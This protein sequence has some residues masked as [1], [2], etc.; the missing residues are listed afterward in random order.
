MRNLWVDIEA[1][2]NQTAELNRESV[3]TISQLDQLKKFTRVVSDTGDFS[4]LKQYAPEDA[5]T[6]PTLIL[7]AAQMPEY[8]YILEKATVEGKKT[9][10][11]GKALTEE[12]FNRLLVGFGVEILKIV[13]NR[14]S[15][16]TAAE[17]SFDVP[18]ILGEAR[19]FIELYAKNG[20]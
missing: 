2:M 18:G 20:I 11:S 15:T 6:N 13:P 16:E 19:R 9:G 12:I 4:S 10:L 3:G 7:K 5:T 14:V 17:K 1:Y 8:A